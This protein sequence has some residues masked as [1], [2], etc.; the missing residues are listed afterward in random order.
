MCANRLVCDIS[1]INTAIK[2]T[3][4]F[5]TPEQKN[6]GATPPTLVKFRRV[7][8]RVDLGALSGLFRALTGLVW[9]PAGLPFFPLRFLFGLLRGSVPSSDSIHRVSEA[10]G[11]S[12]RGPLELLEAGFWEAFLV[13]WSIVVWGC[14][15]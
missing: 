15:S 2:Q 11:V 3:L 14:V 5:V 4:E 1:F 12:S 6:P 10:S 9:T 13:F 7:H 8:F